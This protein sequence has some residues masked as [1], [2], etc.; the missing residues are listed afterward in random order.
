MGTKSP[1]AVKSVE[2][3]AKRFAT[4]AAIIEMNRSFTVF[5]YHSNDE[6]S[7]M[8]KKILLKIDLELAHIRPNATMQVIS[9]TAGKYT[10]NFVSDTSV[11]ERNCDDKDKCFDKLKDFMKTIHIL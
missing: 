5:Q 1:Y 3:R 7:Y 11:V 8:E 4:E 10:M 9:D 2:E 6:L